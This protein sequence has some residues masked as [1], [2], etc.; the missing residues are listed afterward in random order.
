MRIR[1]SHRLTIAAAAAAVSAVLF[2][3]VLTVAHLTMVSMERR[4][5][6]ELIEAPI[7]EVTDA[8][9]SGEP[10]DEEAG[11]Q[12]RVTIAVYLPDGKLRYHSGTAP[13]GFSMDSGEASLGGR[14]YIYST[15]ILGKDRVVAA[16]DWTQSLT[17]LKGIRTI[18]AV[19]LL[20][21][22]L[23]VGFAA[24][25][26][27][28]LMN[29][30][31]RSLTF[32]A[33]ELAADGKIGQL[34]DPDDADFS[35]LA[36]EMNALLQ[37]ISS[38]VERQER[39]VSDVAHDLRTPLTVIRGRLETALMQGSAADYPTAMRT[40]IREAERLSAMA[41]SILRSGVQGDECGEIELSGIL[42]E[43]TD[44]WRPAFVQRGASLDVDAASCFA[45]ISGEEWNSILDNLLDNAFKYG[46]LCCNVS[47]S[48]GDEIEL[49]VRDNGPGVPE[50]DRERVFDRFVRLDTSRGSN[51]HGLGLYLC[52][53]IVLR[54][55]GTI[56]ILAE[57]GMVVRVT[58]PLACHEA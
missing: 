13:I 31:L 14:D 4:A 41:E 10:L 51:G 48:E 1:A 50:N 38:E 54:L 39:L 5:S 37:R 52:A 11:I 8:L 23:I 22:A 45:R 27:A 58:F 35:P 28:G 21:L 47:L 42:T 26:A 9:R 34:E 29:R 2:A 53:S 46:G 30:P 18:F 17:R 12:D 36:R 44:R 16:V 20:P 24:Y 56:Q 55:G 19:L 43:A 15:S 57:A 49:V 7:K 6:L 3:S 25:V 40:A 33:K 32:A